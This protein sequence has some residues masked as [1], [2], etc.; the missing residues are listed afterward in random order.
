MNLVEVVNK[1]YM[2]KSPI[3]KSFPDFRAGDTLIV[4]VKIEE[5]GGN[6]S[7][8]QLFQGICI[9]IR[10]KGHLNGHFRVRKMSGGIGVER[11]FPFYSPSVVKIDLKEKGKSRRA[12]HYYLRERT[13]KQARIAIDYSRD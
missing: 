13:G 2:D 4:H 11:V 1:E 9:A 3:P 8:I 10:R 5:D 12:K 6:K 7:R